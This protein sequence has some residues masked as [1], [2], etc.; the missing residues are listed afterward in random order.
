MLP[1]GE[2]TSC[3]PRNEP[4]PPILGASGDAT[5]PRHSDHVSG[6]APEPNYSVR[7]IFRPCFLRDMVDFSVA[8]E[9]DSLGGA[10][11]LLVGGPRSV[12]VENRRN[13]RVPSSVLRRDVYPIDLRPAGEIKRAHTMI[14][15]T[16]LVAPTA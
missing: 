15:T 13:S 12:F 3:W 8:E 5:H 10:P 1:V 6:L 2:R 4:F 9:P 7:V 16:L 14:G 11:D